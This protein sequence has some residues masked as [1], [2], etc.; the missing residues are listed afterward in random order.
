MKRYL[1]ELADLRRKI[2]PPPQSSAANRPPVDWERRRADREFDRRYR[3]T[4]LVLL[5][6]ASVMFGFGDHLHVVCGILMGLATF[7]PDAL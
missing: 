1:R 4:M 5:T 3:R 7:F 2:A 6:V